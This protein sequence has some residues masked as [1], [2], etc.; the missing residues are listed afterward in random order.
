MRDINV[1]GVIKVDSEYAKVV[2]DVAEYYSGQWDDKVHDSYSNYVKQVQDYSQNM[3]EIRSKSESII[4]EIR[5]FNIDGLI[6]EADALCKEADA[7]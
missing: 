7:V 5:S 6:Q 4:E 2:S 3:H 1:D